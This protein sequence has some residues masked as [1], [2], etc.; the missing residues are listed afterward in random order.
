MKRFPENY[1][2][3]RTKGLWI[4]HGAEV[5][6]GIVHVVYF[7]KPPC[8]PKKLTT[9]AIMEREMLDL[10]KVT[11]QG[12]LDNLDS[13]VKEEK[14]WQEAVREQAKAFAGLISYIHEV[15]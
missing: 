3:K 1:P 6:T 9:K 14:D 5:G 15:K 13:F 7:G 10:S 8:D 4:N 12:C 11:C 2:S